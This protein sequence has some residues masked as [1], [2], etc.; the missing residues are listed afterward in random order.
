MRGRTATTSLCCTLQAARRTATRPPRCLA[1]T[2]RTVERRRR[3]VA[4]D[5]GAPDR[6]GAGQPSREEPRRLRNDARAADGRTTTRSGPQA[7]RCRRPR[8]DPGTVL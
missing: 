7:E 4:G 8:D 1:T 3:P 2:L 6:R 5:P